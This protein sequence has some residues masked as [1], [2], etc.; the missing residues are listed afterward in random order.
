MDA[1]QLA[2][3]QADRT[4]EA[5]IESLAAFRNGPEEFRALLER[6]ADQAKKRLRAM[7]GDDERSEDARESGAQ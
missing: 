4:R 1:R 6:R 3:D 2:Q 7:R 5:A